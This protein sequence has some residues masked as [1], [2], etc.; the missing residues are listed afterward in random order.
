MAA[1][2]PFWITTMALAQRRLCGGFPYGLL[3]IFRMGRSILHS[4]DARSGLRTV[5]RGKLLFSTTVDQR[6]RRAALRVIV[7]E[8]SRSYTLASNHPG[9]I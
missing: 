7:D 8:A 6:D 2:C 1:V 5:L 9:G 3:G 4:R